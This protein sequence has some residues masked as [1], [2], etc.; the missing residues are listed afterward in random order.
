MTAGRL[1]QLLHFY[2]R[3]EADDGAGNRRGVWQPMVGLWADMRAN[4]RSEAFNALRLEGR[5][6]YSV[7]VRRSSAALAIGQGWMAIDR[8]GVRHRVIAPAPDPQDRAWIAMVLVADGSLDGQALAP[9]PAP[10]PEPDPAP[11]PDDP[12]PETGP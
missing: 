6:P 2:A 5:N 7:R 4:M 3:A 9:P 12:E 10:E 1:T 8:R 11:D